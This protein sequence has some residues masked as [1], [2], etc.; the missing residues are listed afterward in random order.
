MRLA[1]ELIIADDRLLYDHREWL[2]PFVSVST[3]N[4][5]MDIYLDNALAYGLSAGTTNPTERGF[6]SLFGGCYQH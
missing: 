1:D 3:G 6:G 5:D 2:I 4:P